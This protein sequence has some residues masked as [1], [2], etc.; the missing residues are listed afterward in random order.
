MNEKL[1]ERKLREEVKKRGGFALKLFSPYFTGLPD[2]II[3]LRG[4]RTAFAE[5]KTTGKKPT[6]RQIA[7]HG[8]LKRLGFKVE[9]IDSEKSLSD[10]FKWVENV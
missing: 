9:V 5:I 7:V 4:A 3:L 1:I 2:R 6:D 8:E 10:F